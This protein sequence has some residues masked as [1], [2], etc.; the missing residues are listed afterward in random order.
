M[1]VRGVRVCGPAHPLEEKVVSG[2]CLLRLF[3]LQHGH[4]ALKILQ[5]QA[6]KG[7]VLFREGREAWQVAF[8]L[9]RIHNETEGGQPLVNAAE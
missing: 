8:R 1:H 5:G 9:S 2:S 4:P 7:V 6:F 3:L